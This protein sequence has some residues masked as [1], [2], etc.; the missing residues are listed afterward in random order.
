MI[1]VVPMGLIDV[2]IPEYIANLTSEKFGIMVEVAENFPIDAFRRNE[3]RGQYLSS[4][5]LRS[6]S[7]RKESD[8]DILLGV[9]DV[10]LYVDSLNFVFGEADP[11]N[12]VAV[13][14]VT[15]LRQGFYGLQND[16]RL[17]LERAGKEAVHEIGHV[18]GLSHCV[19]PT[20]VMYF[21]NR[22]ADTDWKR[23]DF[24]KRCLTSLRS[25]GQI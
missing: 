6:L 9:V 4:D 2:I 16:R 19:D 7:V 23:D 20:C 1:H 3:A 17:L 13:I 12:R 22:L 18:L 15:R 10:D 21:S 24:C 14:S 25:R 11:I 5:M 8:E